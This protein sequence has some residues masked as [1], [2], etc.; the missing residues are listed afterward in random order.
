M[1]VTATTNAAQGM[2]SSDR[3]AALFLRVAA[4]KL[5]ALMSIREK[6]EEWLEKD[7]DVDLALELAFDRVVIM[8]EKA[9]ANADA[10]T[11]DWY[12][13]SSVVSLS[14]DSFSRPSSWY[15]RGLRDAAEFFR[16]APEILDYAVVGAR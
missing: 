4:D 8:S 13:I 14:L 6:D 7:V 2:P 16:Q 11:A 1:N 5:Q 12:K 9:F 3:L 15:G 10:F